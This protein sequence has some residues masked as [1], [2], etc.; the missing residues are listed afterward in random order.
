MLIL[1]FLMEMFVA[2]LPMVYSFRN[3]FVLQ[4]CV[5]MMMALKIETHF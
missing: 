3:L 1:H 4:E 5:L 2:P